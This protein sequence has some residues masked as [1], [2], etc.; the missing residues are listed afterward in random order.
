VISSWGVGD[1]VAFLYL[2]P[3]DELAVAKDSAATS[4]CTQA[5]HSTARLQGMTH[6]RQRCSLESLVILSCLERSV[7]GRDADQLG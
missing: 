2:R 3:S 1:I 5:R 6:R 4:S 7:R